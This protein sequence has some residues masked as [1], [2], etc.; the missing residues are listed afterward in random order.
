MAVSL[1]STRPGAVMTAKASARLGSSPSPAERSGECAEPSAAAHP[2]QPPR[3][4]P[5]SGLPDHVPLPDRLERLPGPLEPHRD[6]EAVAHAVLVDV[7]VLVGEADLAG[8]QQAELVLGVVDLEHAALVGPV[9]GG[10]GA[11]GVLEPFDGVD[12]GRL[13]VEADGR[14]A[15]SLRGR[16]RG[17]KPRRRQTI[18]GRMPCRS[19]A[20]Q[21]W[22]RWPPPG[23][24]GRP[25]PP[26]RSP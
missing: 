21:P 11:R 19:H 22:R 26:G 4:G 24:P 23:S 9:A 12:A 13:A 25:W 16:G 14:H 6:D 8:Q 15:V 2:T 3:C 7:A 20:A 18:T 10:E 17:S 5:A 1:R